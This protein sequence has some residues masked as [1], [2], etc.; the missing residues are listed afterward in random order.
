M[1]R[2]KKITQTVKKK[3]KERKG[4]VHRSPTNTALAAVLN[5]LAPVGLGREALQRLKGWSKGRSVTLRFTA[6]PALVM[7]HL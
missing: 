3:R 6:R 1:S 2:Q 4:W 7:N 5:S